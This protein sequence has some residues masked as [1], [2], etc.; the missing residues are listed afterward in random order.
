MRRP[1]GT[2]RAGSTGET[3]HEPVACLPWDLAAVLE[4]FPVTRPKRGRADA[5]DAMDGFLRD[6]MLRVSSFPPQPIGNPPDW[7]W[8]PPATR[9][10]AFRLH[11]FYMI[12]DV[13]GAHVESGEVRY[14]HAGIDLV[15]DWIRANPLAGR[16]TGAEMAWSDHTTAQR[17]ANWLRFLAYLLG[18]APEVALSRV[19]DLRAVLA[20]LAE[21][22]GLLADPAFARTAHNH[23]FDQALSLV[24]LAAVL[25]TDPRAAH[26]R[27]DGLRRLDRE[28]ALAHT[29]EGA[30]VENSPT[31]ALR[32]ASRY[33]EM[34]DTIPAPVLGEA[35]CARTRDLTPGLVRFLAALVRP[36]GTLG[37]LGDSV[38]DQLRETFPLAVSPE[39]GSLWR[40]AVTRGSSG[41]APDWTSLILPASGYAMLRNRWPTA[42]TDTSAIHAVV[43]LG[44][45]SR[46]HVQ[47][48]DG[49]LGVHA[50]GEDWLIDSGQ[51]RFLPSHPVRAYMLSRRAH[52]VVDCDD[53]SAMALK[54][55]MRTRF[56][57]ATAWSDRAPAPFVT[58]VSDRHPA[59]TRTRTVRLDSERLQVADSIAWRD[60]PASPAVVRWHVPAAYAVTVV[61]PGRVSVVSPR[62]S[63][64][65]IDVEG[66][67]P[68]ATTV[69]TGEV[70]GVVASMVSLD[71]QH[72]EPSTV[73]A[74]T[75]PPAEALD[76][77]TTFTW[78]AGGS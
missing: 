51:S 37:I 48:D 26:W 52:N 29:D 68:S 72:L 6:G 5:I 19:E 49:H 70:D 30:H 10:F 12:D 47:D 4:A 17:V 22:A 74:F 15:L 7:A 20:S 21:H 35:I 57:R 44:P 25:A 65:H 28:I 58:V 27:A 50:F 16:A 56:W 8:Y 18:E 77:H 62:G 38:I 40:W 60:Q 67:I 24:R 64:M 41:M 11:S 32:A 34:L 14:L 54:S 53:E 73:V 69:A 55:A 75:F 42:P 63:V 71:L 45:L 13:L 9:S 76:I 31:Y 36:D 59:C 66:A 3:L 43:K 39:S 1:I 2:A 46:V 23:A 78:S 61:A 33:R